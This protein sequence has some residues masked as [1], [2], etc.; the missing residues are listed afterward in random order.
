MS[1]NP[2]V[3]GQSPQGS[4]KKGVLSSR[5]VHTLL[6]A[7]VSIAML[8][9]VGASVEWAQVGAQLAQ[10]H[11]WALIPVLATLLLHFVLRAVRWQFLLP[12]GEQVPFLVRFDSILVGNLA[13]FILPLRAGEFVRA[14]MLTRKSRYSFPISFVSIIVERF[15]DLA[16][17]LFFFAV[18]VSSLP[19]LPPYVHNGAGV[20]TV[21]GLVILALMIVGSFAPRWVLLTGELFLRPLPA[22]LA[23]KLHRFLDDFLK[24]AAVLKTGSRLIIVVLLSFLVWGSCFL[25][26]QSFFWPF[27]Q[28][29]PFSV[30]VSLSVIV[31]L[32]VAAPSA[33]GFIGVYQAACV[34]GFQ[35][36]GLN[37]DL[38]LAYS[39]VSHFIQYVLFVAYGFYVLA[40]EN[41]SIGELATA[42]DKVE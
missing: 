18:T 33:P 12:A 37:K 30:S 28:N 19:N 38:G 17:V 40:R 29:P 24:G 2:A 4:P 25:T 36:F 42:R 31:A 8:I 32:A 15:F 9:W 6:G 1:S 27:G 16:V 23:G 41:I 35:L 21:L 3:A 26:F 7:S 39:I 13:T 22:G 34:A 11:Y 20:L 5:R 14:F 10:I